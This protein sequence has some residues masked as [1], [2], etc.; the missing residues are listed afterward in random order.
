MCQKPIGFLPHLA[1]CLLPAQALTSSPA[2]STASP[3]ASQRSLCGPPRLSQCLPRCPAC[4]RRDASSLLPVCHPD[5]TG[6]PSSSPSTSLPLASNLRCIGDFLSPAVFPLPG[7]AS[8]LPIWPGTLATVSA[9][10]LC[11]PAPQPLGSPG[12][13]LESHMPSLLQAPTNVVRLLTQPHDSLLPCA[14]RSELS[15]RLLVT[16]F[17]VSAEE[18]CLPSLPHGRAQRASLW[19]ELLCLFGQVHLHLSLPSCRCSCPQP[20]GSRTHLL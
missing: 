15:Q 8:Q 12:R 5:I 20:L 1:L 3:A 14:T 7:S 4:H 6:L 11:S 16:S 18:S 19:R 10:V 2:L 13:S 17:L 9:R